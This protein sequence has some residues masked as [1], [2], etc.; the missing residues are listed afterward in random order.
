[1]DV[2]IEKLETDLATITEKV[3]NITELI[4]V[5]NKEG[6]ALRLLG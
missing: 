3:N 4:Q 5:S 2:S 1:M 6:N